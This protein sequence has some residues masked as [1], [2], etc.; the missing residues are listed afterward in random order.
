ML[1]T[2]FTL[3]KHRF[4]NKIVVPLNVNTISIHELLEQLVFVIR[5]KVGII[6]RPAVRDNDHIP[7]LV[8]EYTPNGR[9]CVGQRKD[10]ETNIHEDGT[11]LEGIYPVADDEYDKREAH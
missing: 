11:S 1:S 6:R 10:G 5:Q 2:H 8:C 7:K 3:P 9:M 4:I